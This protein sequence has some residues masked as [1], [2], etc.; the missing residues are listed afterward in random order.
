MARRLFLLDGMALV[1]RAHFALIRNPI[2]TSKGIN[3]SAIYGFTNTLVDLLG[4]QEPTHIAVVFDT[5]VPTER[6]KIF[7]EYKAQRDAMPEDLSI[8]IPEIKKL[9]KA[10]NIPVIEMDG[11]E[12]DD[13]I[14]TLAKRA[15][16][17]DSECEVFM[18]TP[19]KDFA[20]L[21][22]DRVKIFKPG[23]A[24]NEPEI[25]GIDAIKEH[26]NVQCSEQVIDILGLWGDAS[27]NIPGVPGIG[28]KTAKKLVAQYGGVEQLI[29]NIDEL[30]GKQR[31]NVE[32]NKEQAL[33]SKKLATIIIDVP[34]DLDWDDLQLE[35]KNNEAVSGIFIEFEFNSLGKRI[36]GKEFV[37]G[38]GYDSNEN[39]DD[40]AELSLKNIESVDHDYSHI[41]YDDEAQ[42]RSEIDKL[43][44]VDSFCFDTE[45]TGTDPIHDELLGIAVSCAEGKALYFECPREEAQ[46]KNF[47]KDFTKLFSNPKTEKIGHNLKFDLA[48]LGWSGL[49][50]RGPFFDTMLA[51]TLIFP[52]QK[53]SMDYASESM[54]G[55][56]PI[57]MK[58]LIDEEDSS[59]QLSLIDSSVTDIEASKLAE[60]AAEDA[61]VTYQLAQRLRPLLKEKGQEKV[62]YEIECPLIPV[63]VAMESGGISLDQSVLDEIRGSLTISINELGTEITSLAG[64]EFNLNSPKQLGEVL[65]DDLKLVDKP[66]KTKTGQYKTDEAVLTS[67]APKHRI[68]EAILEYRESAKLKSTY[69]DALP[70]SI[71]KRTGR[72]HSNFGQLLTAT[73]RLVSNSPN[74]QNIP[75]RTAQGREIRKAF[76]ARG[77]DYKILAADYSQIELRVMASISGDDALQSAFSEGLDIHSATASKVYSVDLDSVTSD[78]RRGAKTVNF[79]IIYGISAFGLSQRLNVRRSEA[80]ELIDSYFEQYP[81][82]KEFMSKTIEFAK[83]NGYVETITGR[84]RYLRD[85]NSSNAMIRSAAERTAI[86]TPIQGTAADM[87]KLAMTRVQAALDEGEFD[88]KMI[89][90]V[91]DELLFDMVIDEETEIK[92]MVV[93]E[94]KSALPLNVPITVDVGIGYNWLEAH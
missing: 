70:N 71:A 34:V 62:F 22:E 38:R 41:V 21:V 13:I 55:Y 11:Y 17:D 28:E 8:A 56:T 61:D 1:Y 16:K 76:V 4:K 63:L 60:Y 74:L 52:D 3:S 10:F 94:M 35:D 59:G 44:G 58:S 86:N 26:W 48:V 80:S 50:V 12:A 5:P 46:R 69:V 18:V 79:G 6:H 88:T 36:L 78:M 66:K 85:I 14:G 2:Y 9:I 29:E 7:P 75:V 82:V 73:G 68:V 23:K 87:I 45:T 72:V 51:H 47:I 19:D 20:Q 67:L 49:N 31:E 90:Q 25:I 39:D 54:L 15:V 84:R 93:E 42:R 83:E 24:G 65:F 81:K 77:S 89:L 30:K 53:H 37:A 33:L 40:S 92:E 91:H 57:S 64:R 32:N 27:D 43:V